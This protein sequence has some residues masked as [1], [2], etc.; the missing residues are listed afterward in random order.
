MRA[1]MI[2]ITEKKVHRI[3]T[4]KTQ[5]KDKGN[6]RIKKKVALCQTEKK[7]WRRFLK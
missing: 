3:G 6:R 7:T 1:E 5:Y 2:G 4:V